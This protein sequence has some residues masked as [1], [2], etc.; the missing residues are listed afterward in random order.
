MNYRKDLE[1]T[2][3]YIEN[4]ISDSI[5]L[6]DIAQNVAYSPFHFSRIFFNA[7]QITIM[8]YVRRRRLELAISGLNRGMKIIDVAMEYG[9]STASG[10]SKAFRK[11][12]GIS[13]TNYTSTTLIKQRA[14]LEQATGIPK[15]VLEENVRFETKDSFTVI[16][17]STQPIS[18]IGSSTSEFAAGWESVEHE[19]PESYLY[20]KLN[21]T[22]HGEVGIFLPD[23]NG[24]GRYILGLPMNNCSFAEADMKCVRVPQA[25]YAVFTTIAVD[26]EVNPGT[27]SETIRKT[28]RGI[29]E[30]WLQDS[31]YTYDSTKLDFEYYDE[32]CH[33]DLDAVMEIWIPVIKTARLE[34]HSI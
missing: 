28:W 14:I 11:Y 18:H 25:T 31:D 19:K 16:G 30:N 24:L 20:N 8:E 21:P 33:S 9:F 27:F 5:G 1:E 22:A 29:F 32:R 15:D 12:Y 34:Q 3:K 13:P 17:F 4:N 2:I 7:Y 23:E 6:E 10:F 26:E